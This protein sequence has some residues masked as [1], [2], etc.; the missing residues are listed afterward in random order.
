[1]DNITIRGLT[2]PLGIGDTI[3]IGNVRTYDEPDRPF[4]ETFTVCADAEVAGDAQTFPIALF[5]SPEADDAR[6]RR[7]LREYRTI[8]GG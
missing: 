4:T 1:M 5:D 7:D 3:Q 2:D 6:F 8:F